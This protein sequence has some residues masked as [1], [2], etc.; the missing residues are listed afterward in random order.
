MRVAAHPEAEQDAL[1]C[2]WVMKGLPTDTWIRLAVWLVIGLTALNAVSTLLIVVSM[3]VMLVAGFALFL[4]AVG[5]SL[6]L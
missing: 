4:L 3:A 2:A 1:A 5:T 6:L